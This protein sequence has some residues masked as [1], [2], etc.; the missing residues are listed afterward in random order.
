MPVDKISDANKRLLI[1]A[2]KSL[3]TGVGRIPSAIEQFQVAIHYRRTL[4]D[5]ELAGLPAAW[6]AIPP[7]DEGGLGLVLERDT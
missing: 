3:L 5:E 4:T 1:A 6:C 7:I 2:S